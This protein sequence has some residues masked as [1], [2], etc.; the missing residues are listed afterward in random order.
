MAG[1]R[2]VPVV[3]VASMGVGMDRSM[4]GALGGDGGLH[5]LKQPE[6]R[7]NGMVAGSDGPAGQELAPDLAITGMTLCGLL[8]AVAMTPVFVCDRLIN[9]PLSDKDEP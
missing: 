6:P 3:C 4:S 8:V 1:A 5:G 9:G 7:Q 2:A